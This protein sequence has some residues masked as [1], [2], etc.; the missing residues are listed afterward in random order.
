MNLRSRPAGDTAITSLATVALAA[1]MCLTTTLSLGVAPNPPADTVPSPPNSAA[2][3]VRPA[4]AEHAL[5][6]TIFRVLR[7]QGSAYAR[8][9]NSANWRA[10]TKGQQLHTG[11]LLQATS[12][13]TVQVR[14]QQA[15]GSWAHKMRVAHNGHLTLVLDSPMIIRLGSDAIRSLHLTKRFLNKLPPLPP[16]PANESALLSTWNDAWHRV[17]ALV[18][19]PDSEALSELQLQKLQKQGA[20]V[21]QSAKRINLVSP[22]IGV[23]LHGPLPVSVRLVWEEPIPPP[24]DSKIY[25]WPAR[26]ARGEPVAMTRA[27]FYRLN[28]PAVGSYFVQV[29]GLDGRY[30][31]EARMIHVSG[32]VAESDRPVNGL[33]VERLHEELNVQFPPDRY[34]MVP[35]VQNAPMKQIT[36]S[37]DF[38]ASDTRPLE[39]ASYA[40]ILED[41]RGRVVQRHPLRRP[42]ATL[43]LTPG[44]YLWSFERQALGSDGKLQVGRT[45]RRHLKIMA[46]EATSTQIAPWLS[47]LL[48]GQEKSDLGKTTHIY[49]S[50]EP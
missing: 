17:A 42:T 28:I 4:A 2:T 1:L 45:E 46:P 49:L 3:I 9:P 11:D 13:C 20:A 10:V 43:R 6:G 12:G 26:A 16:A 32:S 18:A 21:A 33:R 48:R 22:T 23:L 24:G 36:V 47:G 27:S 29:T 40:L 35:S 34:I 7:I 37:A 19:N 39:S 8:S 30:Q 25:V 44:D 38:Y 14:Q 5:S 31:S 50:E 15:G 41:Q